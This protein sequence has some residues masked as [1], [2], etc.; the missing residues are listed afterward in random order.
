MGSGTE[1]KRT[2]GLDES[3]VGALASCGSGSL[4]ESPEVGR[5]VKGV[6]KRKRKGGKKCKSKKRKGL[7][8]CLGETE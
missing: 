2:R 4:L 5:G 7:I 6:Q 3:R 8:E 1:A